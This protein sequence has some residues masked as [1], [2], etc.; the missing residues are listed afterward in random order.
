MDNILPILILALIPTVMIGLGACLALGKRPSAK[1]IRLV[2]HFTT[3]ILLGAMMIE[4]LPLIVDGHE[5]LVVYLGFIL[6]ILLLMIIKYFLSY[7]S[8]FGH[9][10]QEEQN[11]QVIPSLQSQSGVISSMAAEVMIYGAMLGIALLV[12]EK[13][14]T[15]VAIGIAF[16]MLSL[17]IA[18]SVT[19]Y[20][21]VSKSKVLMI[22]LILMACIL[23]A[24]GISASITIILTGR[25]LVG[26]ITFAFALLFYLVVDEVMLE[27][28]YQSYTRFDTLLVFIGFLIVLILEEWH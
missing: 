9:L 19:F 25:L 10:Q 2:Q 22:S 12:G 17:G 6:G 24:S 14:G 7:E 1:I 5:R 13:G 4:I 21:V 8:V 18:L 20:P 28:K 16:K 26:C 3:G 11:N 15:L 27:S 23:L